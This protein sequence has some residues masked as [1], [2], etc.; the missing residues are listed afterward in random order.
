MMYL[1]VKL[2]HIISATLL[3]GTGLGSAF[4]MLMA[5]RSGNMNVMAETNRIV[6]IADFCFTTP[7]VIL[8][9][10]TGLYLLNYFGISWTSTWSLS[11]LSLYVFVGACWL[12]VVWLQIWLRNRAKQLGSPDTQYQFYMKIWMILGFMAFPAVLILY[13]LMVFKPFFGA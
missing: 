8:Q 11:V 5:Y 1:T 6:V 2:I 3:F 12:P 7:T 10:V 4:Y 9:L 13:A